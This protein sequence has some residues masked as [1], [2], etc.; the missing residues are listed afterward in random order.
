M[1]DCEIPGS[2]EDH[3][4]PTRADTGVNSQIVYVGKSADVFWN[5]FQSFTCFTSLQNCFLPSLQ[6]FPLQSAYTGDNNDYNNLES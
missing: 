3:M 1:Y 6:H 2:K 5:L 4:F